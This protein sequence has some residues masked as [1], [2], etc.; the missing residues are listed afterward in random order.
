VER[1]FGNIATRQGM[2]EHLPF[3]DKSFDY[4]LSRYS[5]HH[6][7]DFDAGLREAARVLKPG[8]TA[9]FADAVSPGRPLLDTHIQAIELLRDPSH[10]RNYSP[11]EWQ[12]AMIRAGL[13]PISFGAH[14]V[15]LDFAN[16]IERMRTPKVQADAIRALQTAMSESVARHFE[17][18]PD[19]SFTL[20]VGLFQASKPSPERRFSGPD[21]FAS[22]IA[23]RDP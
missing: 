2:V 7:H 11:S 4:V 12:A 16:W 5:A 15:R 10:V 17:I 23:R 3:E 8:G 18:A 14:R 19:G 6:W 13:E 20:D 9:G 22:V 21:L 1:G